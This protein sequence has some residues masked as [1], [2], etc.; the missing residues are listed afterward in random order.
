M[1]LR[2]H[3]FGIIQTA[4][5]DIDFSRKIVELERQG[6][7]AGGAKAPRGLGRR[8][9]PLWLTG[10]EPETGF[11]YAE[12]RDEGSPTRAS[13]NRTVAIGFMKGQVFR[14]V[15]NGPTKTPTLHHIPVPLNLENL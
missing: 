14:S 8:P 5:R 3:R 10:K 13:A 12:P 1:I 6:C 4:E 11:R 9:E 15:A 2:Q 7:P